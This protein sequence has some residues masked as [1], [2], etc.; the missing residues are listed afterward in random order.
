MRRLRNEL[1]VQPED[2]T[3]PA[4]LHYYSHLENICF[5]NI[6]TH[7]SIP[8]HTPTH[9]TLAAET[10]AGLIERCTQIAQRSRE[11]LGREWSPESK[12]V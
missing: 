2:G 8:T 7:P 4:K 1:Q 12:E 11:R 6:N 9:K 5:L 3:N 10:Q